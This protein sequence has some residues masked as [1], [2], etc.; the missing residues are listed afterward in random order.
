MPFRKFSDRL[1]ASSPILPCSDS[2]LGCPGQSEAGPESFA[3]ASNR[4]HEFNSLIPIK[5]GDAQ[6][7]KPALASQKTAKTRLRPQLA[8]KYGKLRLVCSTAPSP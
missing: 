7:K 4:R 2:R 1:I 8:A 3:T 5:L 6:L